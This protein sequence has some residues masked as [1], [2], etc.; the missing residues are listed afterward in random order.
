MNCYWGV[1][2]SFGING[3]FFRIFT[4]ESPNRFFRFFLAKN[5]ASGRGGSIGLGRISPNYWMDISGCTEIFW[6]RRV[7]DWCLHACA[8]GVSNAVETFGL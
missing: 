3:S 1:E 4:V 5:L 6:F 7:F 8:K 2:G